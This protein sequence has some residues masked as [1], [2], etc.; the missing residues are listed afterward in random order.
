MPT[1]VEEIVGCLPGGHRI[2]WEMN[3]AAFGRLSAAGLLTSKPVLADLVIQLL[4][5][6]FDVKGRFIRYR[7]PRQKGLFVSEAINPGSDGG[8]SDGDTF[9]PPRLAHQLSRN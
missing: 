8:S 4:S 5:Q 3:V 7:F 9:G 1:L 2:S 6:P